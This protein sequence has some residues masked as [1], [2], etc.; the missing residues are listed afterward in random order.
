MEFRETL[1]AAQRNQQQKS[2]ENA[3][4]KARFDPPKKEQ[5]QRDRLSANIQKFL[6]KKD[7]EEKQKRLEAQKKREELSALRD[8]KALRKIQKTLKV[9]KSANKSVIADAIDRD[10]TAVTRDGP[11]QPDQDDYGYESQEAAAIYEKMMEKYSKIPDVP[12][13]PVGNNAVKKDLNGTRE[14]VKHALRHEDDPVPHKRRRKGE[15]GER[16]SSP[17][18]KYEPEK[19][20]VKPEKPKFRKPAPP[21]MDFNQ[22]LKLAEQKKSQP[23]EIGKKKEAISEAEPGA[24]RP[25]TKK[26]RREYEEEMARRQRRLE[27]LEGE[28]GGGKKVPRDD[29]QRDVERERRPEPSTGF[30]RIPKM[31]DKL[32]N[33]RTDSPSRPDRPTDRSDRPHERPDRP[34]DR[35]D[36]TSERPDRPTDRLADRER[37]EREKIEKLQKERDRLRLDKD[38]AEREKERTDRERLDKLKA[39]RE[40]IERDIARLNSDREKLEKAKIKL[41]NSSRSSDK[42]NK[43]IDKSVDRSKLNYKESLKQDVNKNIDLKSQNTYRIDKNSNERKLS[44][45]SKQSDGKYMNGHSSQGKPVPKQREQAQQNGFKDKALLAKKASAEGSHK[46]NDK[47]MPESKGVPSKRPDDR[48]V[49]AS[50]DKAGPSK[51]KVTNTFDFDKHINC[52]GKNGSRKPD[53]SR[54][55]PPGD[56]KRKGQDL[57]KKRRALDSESEYDSELDDFIDDGD[58]E[59]D[60]SKHIKEI[61]GYDK[62][63]YRDM[64]DDDDPMMESSFAR[65]QRE[66]YISKKIGIMEDLE[67]MRMEAM[68]KKKSKKGRRISDD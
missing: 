28:K 22:L 14:R 54:Q 56:V 53:G 33:S 59:M 18:T 55:F 61:F 65:Q 21:P 1:L 7:E 12:K 23:I 25:M 2:S 47:R 50:N 63:K 42:A 4:Y 57:K 31:S 51:S 11:D 52:L 48:K 38:K 49:A 45:A 35:A 37:I 39:E 8:P 62:S 36:R 15:N 68:E 20:E 16:E 44:V 43:G 34:S 67:D 32:N 13:F 5:K 58:D 29:R 24:E 3:Y 64:D 46:L 19:K 30:G 6:A 10:N 66:E 60:Y 17:P 40:R 27:R 41:E 9:I 26:Q